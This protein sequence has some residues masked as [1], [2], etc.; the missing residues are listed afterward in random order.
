MAKVKD[1]HCTKCD[2]HCQG[3]VDPDGK[4]LCWDCYYKKWGEYPKG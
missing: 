3:F 4:I 2:A 1:T